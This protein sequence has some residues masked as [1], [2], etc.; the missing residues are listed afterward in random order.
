MLEDIPNWAWVLLVAQGITLYWVEWV[1][2]AT[3]KNYERIMR[4]L[5]PDVYQE[6]EED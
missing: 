1:G 2:K 5:R 4:Q 3:D 6:A